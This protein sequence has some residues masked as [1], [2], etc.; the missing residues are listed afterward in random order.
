L[1]L[2]DSGLRQLVRDEPVD[3]ILDLARGL[4]RGQF[5]LRSPRAG[6][7]RSLPMSRTT[8]DR[9]LSTFASWRKSAGE[10]TEALLADV[11]RALVSARIDAEN[12]GPRCELIWTGAAEGATT[13]RA[14]IQVIDEMLAAAKREVLV[15]T[16]SVWIGSEAG[17]ILTRL[18][19]LGR[20][21]VPTTFIVDAGYRE[22]W[23]VQQIKEN[24]PPY[25]PRPRLFAW[26]HAT[27]EI[28]KLH[29]KVLLVDRRDLLITSANLTEHAMAGNV[30]FG[31]R[32]TGTPA[33]QASDHFRALLRS[34][35]V[36]LHEW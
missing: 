28:A 31:V 13:A 33:M 23:S 15:V 14:T 1:S 34:G 20:G 9:I 4:E 22:G 25:T 18:A 30:E 26:S 7:T 16:Y 24:W 32:V 2:L 3:L 6:L 29:A 11:L 5:K 36:Q 21:G 17:R 8:Q 27:D 35:N 19:E 10:D 12:R